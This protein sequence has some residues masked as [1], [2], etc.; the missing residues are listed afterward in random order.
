MTEE[1]TIMGAVVY[2]QFVTVGAQEE[3]VTTLLL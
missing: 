3:M 1:V 2:G